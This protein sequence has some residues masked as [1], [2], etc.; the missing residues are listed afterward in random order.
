VASSKTCTSELL[1]IKPPALSQQAVS[2]IAN[3][4]RAEG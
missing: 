4:F 2:W 1:L 3:F